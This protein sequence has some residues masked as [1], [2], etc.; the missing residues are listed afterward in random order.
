MS[1]F[2]ISNKALIAIRQL[3]EVHAELERRAELVAK[4]ASENGRVSGYVV[5][6]LVLEKPRGAAS[7]MAT[8]HA[9]N[10]NRRTLAL[11]KALGVARD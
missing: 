5:T 3:P 6:D 4:Q 8:G 9:R 2:K 11:V 1:N 10:H 7:V